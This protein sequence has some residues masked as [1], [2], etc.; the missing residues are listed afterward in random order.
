MRTME[1]GMS[2]GGDCGRMVAVT[3]ALVVGWF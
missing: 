3:N 1:G 2:G